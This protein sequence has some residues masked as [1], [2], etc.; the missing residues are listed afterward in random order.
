MSAQ[1]R[2]TLTFILLSLISIFLAVFFG[3]SILTTE[4]D[5]RLKAAI[6]EAEQSLPH[7][8]FITDSENAP[9]SK[10]SDRIV[11]VERVVDG[12]TVVVTNGEKIRLIG[13]DTPELTG[14]VAE[15]CYGQEAAA[16]TTSLLLDKEVRLEFDI[17]LDDRYD[18]TLAY[19][20]LDEQLIN[21]KLV[22]AGAARAIAYPPNTKWQ[23]QFMDAEK[24]AR[25]TKMGI[26][27]VCP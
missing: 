19:I 17:D 7:E 18:R 27:T 20:W 3:Q 9:A 8:T 11:T 24:V 26:W 6:S 14:P 21:T 10:Y 2:A 5:T 1:A 22:E 12:D 13:V 23:Q 16:L 15:R 4:L 25:E